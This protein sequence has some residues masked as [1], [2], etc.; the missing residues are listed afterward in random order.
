[1]RRPGLFPMCG[2]PALPRAR[3]LREWRVQSDPEPGGLR[4]RQQPVF[5]LHGLIAQGQAAEGHVPLS[6]VPL[7]NDDPPPLVS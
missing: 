5:H 3:G 1:L 4:L 6:F 7:V 2:R